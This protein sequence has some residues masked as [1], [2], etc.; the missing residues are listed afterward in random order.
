[1]SCI[2]LINIALCNSVY[3]SIA[4]SRQENVV[5]QMMVL[6]ES[7][8]IYV[9]TFLLHSGNYSLHLLNYISRMEFWYKFYGFD[10]FI[11]DTP[12]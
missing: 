12:I 4:L 2:L 11:V 9:T 7:L 1:M 6:A 3:Y 8:L 10:C 5:K